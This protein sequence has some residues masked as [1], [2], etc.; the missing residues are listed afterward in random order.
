MAVYLTAAVLEQLAEGQA[1]IDQHIVSC[2]T[3]GA[4]QPC[5]ERREGE[6]VFLRY[7][8][9]PRRTPGRTI[10]VNVR[11]NSDGRSWLDNAEHA[12]R[13]A[14]SGGQMQAPHD[15]NLES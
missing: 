5:A 10:R 6:A 13:T 8:M 1:V 14:M 9:L 12:S 4:N 2:A 3:C 7:G 15:S 11:P